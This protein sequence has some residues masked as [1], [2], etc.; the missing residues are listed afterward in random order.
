[1]KILL[2][3]ISRIMNKNNIIGRVDRVDIRMQIEML[4][5]KRCLT[6]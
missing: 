2:P 3:I 4:T 5:T 6:E 1:M